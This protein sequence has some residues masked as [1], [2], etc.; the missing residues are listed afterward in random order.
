MKSNKPPKKS[1]VARIWNAFLYSLEGLGQAWKDEQAFRQ[2]L[3]LTVILTPCAL[4]IPV[5]IALRTVLVL[6]MVLVLIIEL[7]NS[8]IEAV[9]DLATEELHDLAKKAKD[10]GS[11]AVFIG[12]LFSG[13][14]WAFVLYRWLLA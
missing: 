2:E 1:A 7:I 6:S 9:T 13:G 8:S 10:C 3:I 12:L 11:A 5:D 4:F 14:M